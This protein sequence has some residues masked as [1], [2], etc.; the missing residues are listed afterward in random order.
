MNYGTSY[1]TVIYPSA[2]FSLDKA[3]ILLYER[4]AYEALRMAHEALN[5]AKLPDALL[6]TLEP[7]HSMGDLPWTL[8][9]YASPRVDATGN[10][11]G[12]TVGTTPFT[13]PVLLAICHIIGVPLF[14]PDSYKAWYSNPEKL[15]TSLQSIGGHLATSIRLC[16]AEGLGNSLRTFIQSLNYNLSNFSDSSSLYNSVASFL[17]NHEVAHAYVG[18]L[19]HDKRTLSDEECRAFEFIVDLVATDWLY[20]K[21]VK[22]TPDT[23]AYREWAGYA[24]HSDAIREN[25]RT[26][27]NSQMLILLFVA[28]ARGM[29]DGAVSLN[30]GRFHPHSLF[31][32]VLQMAH[33]STRVS[34]SHRVHFPDDYEDFLSDIWNLNLELCCR[35]GVVRRSDIDAFLDDNHYSDI[36]KA[37]ELIV[38]FDVAQLTPLKPVLES[39]A[40]PRRDDP[41]Q[42]GSRR[43]SL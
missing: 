37:A 19:T 34:S 15:R 18:Q 9:A 29:E 35:A 27:L 24:T 23:P 36:R 1:S 4:F 17:V 14:D 6:V 25:A 38:E 2:V 3:P 26:V 43:R 40:A 11:V 39:M 32:Y 7:D 21:M 42:P 20:A 22:N 12:F 31:R 41:S 5:D 13:P 8:N 33:F 30:G 10:L 16:E 28:L